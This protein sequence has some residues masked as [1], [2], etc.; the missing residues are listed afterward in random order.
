MRAFAQLVMLA[1]L[2]LLNSGCANIKVHALVDNTYPLEE[3]TVQ[4]GS[5]GGK[6]LLLPVRGMISDFEGVSILKSNPSVLQE[7]VSQLELAAKDPEIKCVLLTIN[8][9]GGTVTG[10]DMLYHEIAKFK[11][12]RNV[13][14]VACMLDVAASGGYMA[15]LPA[16]V[17]YAHPTTVTGSVGVVFFQPKL[18][19][20]MDMIGVGVD[21]AKSGDRKDMGSPFRKSTDEEAKLFQDLVD[22][23]DRRFLDAVK[24]DRKIGDDKLKEISSGGVYLAEDALKLG[25]VDKIGYMSDAVSAAGV[26]SGLGEKPTV[27]VYRRTE[28]PNDNLYNSAL[29]KY[30]G[31]GRLL[32]L[33]PLSQL[34]EMHAGFYYIWAPAAGEE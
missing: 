17:I 32:N 34:A 10:S 16:D 28:F 6:V 21:V 14:I 13:K 9:P 23:L 24:A 31:S 4:E 26:L 11:R 30:Q 1:S 12:E 25:L 33:G 18:H 29:D 5:R 19:R 3:Y 7:L 2:S 27:V 8:S 20:L 22:R 15:A